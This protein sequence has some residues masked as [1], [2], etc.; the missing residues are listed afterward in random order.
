VVLE[1]FVFKA[2]IVDLYDI[3]QRIERLEWRFELNDAVYRKIVCGHVHSAYDPNRI[4]AMVVR[5]NVASIAAISDRELDLAVDVAEP[6][7]ELLATQPNLVMRLALAKH[8]KKLTWVDFDLRL[9]HFSSLSMCSLE[10]A[11]SAVIVSEENWQVLAND[12]WLLASSSL[13]SWHSR[14]MVFAPWL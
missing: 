9:D 4:V 2:L 3:D 10:R 11:A 12:A 8:F 5:N 7:I 14:H 13:G 6:E 1:G